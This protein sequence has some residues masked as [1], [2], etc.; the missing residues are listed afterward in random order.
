[1]IVFNP[2]RTFAFELV[3]KTRKPTRTRTVFRSLNATG[4]PAG[5]TVIATCAKG[6]ARKRYVSRHAYGKVALK[7]LIA[8]ALPKGTKIVVE[9][10]V[11][12]MVT[13]TRTLTVRAS[14]RPAVK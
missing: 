12:G 6:C 4:V 10:T 14:R 3:F 5:A 13:A 2:K 9:V 8:A 1:V 7:S 11:P